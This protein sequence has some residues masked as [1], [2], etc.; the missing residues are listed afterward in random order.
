M[1]LSYN[2]VFDNTYFQQKLY[3]VDNYTQLDNLCTKYQV[4]RHPTTSNIS[5]WELWCRAPVLMAGAGPQFVWSTFWE[6]WLSRLMSIYQK[7][8]N[9]HTFSISESILIWM[10]AAPH[11]LSSARYP[12][13]NECRARKVG[14]SSKNRSKTVILDEIP[15][16][17]NSLVGVWGGWWVRGRG[18]ICPR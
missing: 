7:G 2:K 14:L 8:N 18:Q 13:Q 16:F 6:I 11:I 4:Y 3:T 15:R 12:S 17:P 10:Y 9:F 5:R 1:G